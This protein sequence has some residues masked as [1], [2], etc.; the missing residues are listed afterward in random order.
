MVF[1]FET[2]YDST[3]AVSNWEVKHKQ[4]L[5]GRSSLPASATKVKVKNKTKQDG[6]DWTDK[7]GMM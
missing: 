6:N 4:L 7:E 5:D 1:W 2:I 3:L